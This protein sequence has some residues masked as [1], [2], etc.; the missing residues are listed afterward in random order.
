MPRARITAGDIWRP[1]VKPSLGGRLV[2]R[3]RN[4]VFTAYSIERFNKYQWE[5]MRRNK[6][7]L[8]CVGLAI[9]DFRSCLRDQMIGKVP[10][11]P[12]NE[13]RTRKA[14]AAATMRTTT[15]TAGAPIRV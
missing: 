10:H 5:W 13:V 8:N 1:Y 11:W 15:G 3:K 9:K 6:P 14:R 7:S 4:T 2:I 12:P